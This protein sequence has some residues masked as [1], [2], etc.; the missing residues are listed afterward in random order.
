MEKLEDESIEKK[1]ARETFVKLKEYLS[2]G[3]LLHGSKNKIEV[4]EPRQAHDDNRESKVT[5]LHGVYAADDI[6]VPVFMALFDKKD[7]TKKGWTSYYHATNREEITVG[8]KNV[9]FTPGYIHVLPNETFQKMEDEH[10]QETV[11]FEPVT[12]ID[13]I[14]ITPEILELLTGVTYEMGD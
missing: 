5:N 7:P 2:Q 11:S 6:R 9:T 12:P 1:E 13:V 10:G 3:Y 8:G 4:I 14:R